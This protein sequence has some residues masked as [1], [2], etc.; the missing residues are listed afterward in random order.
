MG[1]YMIIHFKSKSVSSGILFYI[2]HRF[3]S[4]LSHI[5]YIYVQSYIMSRKNSNLFIF[6]MNYELYRYLTIL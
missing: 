1:Y 6:I 3:I 5:S 2:Y 4:Y